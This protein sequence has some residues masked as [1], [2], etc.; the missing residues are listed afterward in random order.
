LGIGSRNATQQKHVFQLP[1]SSKT[2]NA[3]ETGVPLCLARPDGADAELRVFDRLAQAVSKQL[4]GL[5]NGIA[6]GYGGD[7]DIS[8]DSATNFNNGATFKGSD[9]VFEVASAFL[10]AN[11]KSKTFTVRVFSNE[12]VAT[13]LDIAAQILRM[14]HPKT[15]SP[16]DAKKDDISKTVG[17]ASTSNLGAS[18]GG[19]GSG[20]GGGVHI[21]HHSHEPAPPAPTMPRLFP[22]TLER[23]GQ[24]GY[25]VEWADGATI[26]YSMAS[27]VKAAGGKLVK[28]K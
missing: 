1:L 23:K 26:I 14:A 7:E 25:S 9:A 28:M 22:V 17:P 4:F 3:N 6:I 24:F 20:G 15:G 5:Q 13:Q 27:L 21:H 11:D 16:M 8:E 2:T 10:K 18:G 19:C 12:G